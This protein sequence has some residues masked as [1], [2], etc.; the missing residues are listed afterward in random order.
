MS[1][2]IRSSRRTSLTGD[3]ELRPVG[4][5]AVMLISG[6][7]HSC[8]KAGGLLAH[9]RHSQGPGGQGANEAGMKGVGDMGGPESESAEGG[10]RPRRVCW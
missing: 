1:F 6:V 5:A 7:E 3:T 4:E 2:Y 9:W 8:S 10:D